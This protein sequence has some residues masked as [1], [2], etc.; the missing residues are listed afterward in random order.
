[1]AV[2]AAAAVVAFVYNKN[3]MNKSRRINKFNN[4]AFINEMASGAVVLGCSQNL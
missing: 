4:T 1:M 3:Y 2:K